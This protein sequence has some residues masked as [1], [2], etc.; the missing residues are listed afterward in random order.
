MKTTTIHNSPVD[1]IMD[2][3]IDLDRDFRKT[4]NISGYTIDSNK[5]SV[6][7]HIEGTNESIIVHYNDNEY[8]PYNGLFDVSRWENSSTQEFRAGFYGVPYVD[9]IEAI[10]KHLNN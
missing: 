2:S 8:H 3:I 10:K 7:F 5:D 9:L 1:I 6:S 4:L